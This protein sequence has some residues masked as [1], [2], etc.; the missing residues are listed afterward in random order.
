MGHLSA[1]QRNVLALWSYGM[2]LAQTCSMSQ[3]VAVLASHLGEKESNL[4]QRLREWY[5][6]REQK[7]GK[8]R[9]DWEV[10]QSF[11]PLLAWIVSLWPAEN[12]QLVLAMDATSLKQCFVVLSISVV[13]RSCAIPVAWAVLPQGQ[14]G[15]WKP[16]WLALLQS[17]QNTIPSTW[18]VLVMA[19]RGLF[20]RWLYT[21]IRELGWHP[22]LRLNSDCVYRL[23]GQEACHPMKQL[24]AKPGMVWVGKVNCFLHNPL[25]TT[26]LACWGVTC[27]EPWLILTD[28]PPDQATAHWYGFRSWIESGFK[29]LKRGGWQWQRTRMTDPDRAARLWLALAVATLWVLSVGGEADASRPASNLSVLPENH[30][31]RRR[32]K[33]SHP[34]RLL[35]CF[36]QG[37][38]EILNA[39]RLQFPISLGHFIPEPWPLKTYP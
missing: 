18:Q 8:Q 33:C 4:R 30:I 14:P 34:V 11:G 37:R 5:W 28:L 13:I 24:L 12:R 39:I 31:A 3:V 15:A 23:P 16:H 27:Q 29:D 9:V 32:K 36:S 10:R 7:H 26:L 2:I 19:D 38:I 35:S 25:D 1:P 6:E 20:A 21:A 17:L 22:F